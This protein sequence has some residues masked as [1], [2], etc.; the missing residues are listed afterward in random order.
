ML[1]RRL[2][3]VLV[4]ILTVVGVGLGCGGGGG[5]TTATPA[6]GTGTLDLSYLIASAIPGN[7]TNLRFLGTDAGGATVFSVTQA[8][9]DSATLTVPVALRTMQ[10]DY[11]AGNAQVGQVF[12]DV[13]LGSDGRF[14]FVEPGG[15]IPTYQALKLDVIVNADMWEA[16]PRMI[17][18]GLG[19]TDII[20]VPG[21]DVTQP[22]QSEI[23]AREAG[24]TWN[25]VD[26]TASGG[27]PTLDAFTSAITPQAVAVTYGVPVVG[28]AGLPVEF[29][30]PIRPSTLDP[31]DFQ[32]VMNDGTLVTPEASSIVPNAD[33]NER[34]VA[35]LFGQFGNRL[36]P[37]NP[38]ARYPA[39]VNV[40]A[41]ATPLQLVGPGGQIVSA[42]GMG[43]DSPG[44]P[45]TDPDVPPGERGG[46]RLVGAKITRMSAVGDVAPTFIAGASPNDGITL[47]GEQEAQYRLRV[48]TSGG[49]SPDGVRGVWPDEYSR[50][51]RVH[52]TTAGG[53]T[54][55]LEEVGVPYDVDGATV[56][57]VG[58]AE[59]GKLTN[60]YDSCFIEDQD[61]QLD[62][63]LAGDEAAMRK[64]TGVEVPSVAPYSPFYNPG[65][66][67]NQPSPGVR[68]SA[69]SKP[70][71]QAV[72][73]AIDDPMTVTFIDLRRR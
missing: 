60:A 2:A 69:P 32:I 53:Q 48:Y 37:D 23:L 68:Y 24:G 40:V 9:A 26:C 54:V 38:L 21:L 18:G 63:I 44:T 52:A 41:D 22:A 66:P 1:S 28:G 7:V 55:L 13:D 6:P 39:R 14:R 71:L 16:Q 11:L 29:S 65:G 3:L 30:W 62:I 19:F 57:V 35:V 25:L 45:Y 33:Y 64:I 15:D 73:Q 27:T 34:A 49:F 5:T 67:G 51:F 42:V 59:L 12:F 4:L 46:P 31:T 43:A 56:R 72:L 17:A 36:A 10:I 58:L 61:N 47:Y 20:G 70:H 50:Y 8:P